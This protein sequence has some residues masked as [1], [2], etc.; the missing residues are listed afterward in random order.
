VTAVLFGPDESQVARWQAIAIPIT[1]LRQFSAAA[2]GDWPTFDVVLLDLQIFRVDTSSYDIDLEEAVKSVRAAA[3]KNPDSFWLL[4]T[5]PVLTYNDVAHRLARTLWDVLRG[6]T[7]ATQVATEP[8]YVS[9]VIPQVEAWLAEIER[10][11]AIPITVANTRDLSNSEWRCVRRLLGN[12]D[13]A[14]CEP[15]GEGQSEAIVLRADPVMNGGAAPTRVIKIGPAR[16]I[17]REH[18]NYFEFVHQR[19]GDARAPHHDWNDLWTAGSSAAI[20]YSFAGGANPRPLASVMSAGDG[21][22]ALHDLWER[23]LAPWLGM[24]RPS[25]EPIAAF[26][27]A[28]LDDLGLD[29]VEEMWNANP[30]AFAGAPNPVPWLRNISSRVNDV[31][32]D[33]CIA[34]GDL[35]GYNVLVDQHSQSWLIDFYHTGWKRALFDSA[36]SDAY[37]MLHRVGASPSAVNRTDAEIVAG[38]N[39]Y[40]GGGQPVREELAVVRAAALDVWGAPSAALLHLARACSALRL[41]QYPSTDQALTKEV[42]GLAAAAARALAPNWEIAPEI[43]P[44]E[45]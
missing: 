21:C 43:A 44:I 23:V 15:L 4:I 33:R 12:C 29:Q 14:H 27:A 6:K 32:L 42:A 11:N 19:L 41:L 18:L 9:Q 7:S 39:A 37:L 24:R 38:E 28:F 45:F 10:I 3:E 34:H 20:S 30:P 22:P 35:H 1:Y 17:L 8:H 16:K 40:Y 13:S 5:P 25:T 26:V 2:E 36:G 31:S